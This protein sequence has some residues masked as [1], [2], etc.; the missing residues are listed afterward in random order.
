MNA[1]NI[2]IF[3]KNAKPCKHCL[4]ISRKG[5][6]ELHLYSCTLRYLNAVMH[7]RDSGY[8]VYCYHVFSTGSLWYVGAHTAHQPFDMALSK[9]TGF[10]VF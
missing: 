1:M 2:K 3:K 10:V 7:Y 5:V 8:A 6:V 4:V 9:L